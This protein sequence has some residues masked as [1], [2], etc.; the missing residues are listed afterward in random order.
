[1]L[2]RRVSG[3]DSDREILADILDPTALADGPQPER[4]GFMETPCL[5]MP[6]EGGIVRPSPESLLVVLVL[7]RCSRYSHESSLPSD[8]RV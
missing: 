7:F 3:Q 8:R 6:I 4:D 2:D 1:M 5:H